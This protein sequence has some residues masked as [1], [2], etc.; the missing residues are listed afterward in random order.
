MANICSGSSGFA[1]WPFMPASRHS[2]T[3]SSKALAVMAIMGVVL[4]SGRSSARMALVAE[5]PSMTGILMSIRTASYQPAG[6]PLN[7]SRPRRPFSAVS[8]TMPFSVSRLTAISRFSSL[9]SQ[10]SAL[11]PLRAAAPPPAPPAAAVW[12]LSA[13]CA[14]GLRSMM[15]AEPQ[16]E[17][18]LTLM[19]PPMR[20]TSFLVMAVPS[21]VPRVGA[22]PL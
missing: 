3:S 15:K 18:L 1:M 4:A 12:V 20:S 22:E 7:F 14:C 19:A 11:A 21:P 6:A 13:R 9:S 16:P 8:T 5:S 2:R 10:S 17:L